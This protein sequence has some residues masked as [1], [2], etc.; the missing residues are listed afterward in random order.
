MHERCVQ[1]ADRHI[2]AVDDLVS[3]VQEQ[4]EEVLFSPVANVSHQG[5][6]IPWTMDTRGDADPLLQPASRKLKGGDDRRGLR[7]TDPF[8]SGQGLR[9]HRDKIGRAVM[10]EDSSCDIDHGATF[11]AHP[12]HHGKEFIIPEPLRTH[13]LDLLT[14]EINLSDTHYLSVLPFGHPRSPRKRHT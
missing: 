2:L 10:F 1:T 11:V 7:P 8:Q 6:R 3:C 5:H 9:V 4:S 12:Q 14:W 13:P